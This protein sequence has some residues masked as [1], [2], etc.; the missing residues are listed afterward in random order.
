MVGWLSVALLVQSEQ[1]VR[2]AL[3]QEYLIAAKQ[4]EERRLLVVMD[5]LCERCERV[6]STLLS[7]QV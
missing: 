3:H 4:R 5:C 6:M 1:T 7:H 2:M